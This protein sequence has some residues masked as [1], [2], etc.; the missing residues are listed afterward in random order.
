MFYDSSEAGL[1]F[2]G[3]LSSLIIT[4]Y[5][6]SVSYMKTT[7]ITSPMVTKWTMFRSTPSSWFEVVQI[8]R[9]GNYL[10]GCAS[11]TSSG[12]SDYGFISIDLDPNPLN[13]PS[14]G[15]VYYYSDSTNKDM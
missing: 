14:S 15:S 1:F 4:P 12:S 2:G 8:A 10:F 9:E 11:D 13:D 7:P 6:L 5:Y 3:Q